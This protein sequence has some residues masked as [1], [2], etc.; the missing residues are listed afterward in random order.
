ME[1]NNALVKKSG[2]IEVGGGKGRGRPKTSWIG[3]V[4]KDM[5]IREVVES[6]SQSTSDIPSGFLPSKARYI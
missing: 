4:K 1:P 6:I 2:S 3:I 5:I